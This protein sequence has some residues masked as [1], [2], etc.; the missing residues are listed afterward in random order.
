VTF[1]L[2]KS[3]VSTERARAPN[4]WD[5]KLTKLYGYD[6]TGNV[7][8]IKEVNEAAGNTVVT[9]Q[10]F[11]QDYLR[12]LVDAWTTTASTCQT[13]PSQAAVGG[14]D[15]CWQSFT[16]DVMGNRKTDTSHTASGDTI[17]DYVPP[18]TFLIVPRRGLLGRPARYD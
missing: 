10:C 6:P 3:Q 2:T 16:Y 7:T 4:T 13:D 12:R 17:R 11:E 14:L 1:R 9:Q 8:S 5:E 15:S 18:V